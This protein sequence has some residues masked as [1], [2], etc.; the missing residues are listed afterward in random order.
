MARPRSKPQSSAML[1]VVQLRTALGETQQSFAVRL[2]LAMNTVA[3][4]ETQRD[5]GCCALIGFYR[6]AIQEGLPQSA[7][8]ILAAIA[9]RLGVAEI[10]VVLERAA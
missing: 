1:A 6:L 8:A 3:R 4:Y 5:A 2:G 10:S 7:A 9:E